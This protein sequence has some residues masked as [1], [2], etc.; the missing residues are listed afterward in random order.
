VVGEAV[1]P[2]LIV[3]A[4]GVVLHAPMINDSA[5]GNVE[6]FFLIEISK[7]SRALLYQ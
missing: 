7:A 4:P 2:R 6:E 1:L 3:P 5:L